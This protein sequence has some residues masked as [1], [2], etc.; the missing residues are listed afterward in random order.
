MLKPL[1]IAFL[2]LATLSTAQKKDGTI[3]VEVVV[4]GAETVPEPVKKQMLS[5]VAKYAR[6]EAVTDALVFRLGERLEDEF[7]QHGYF[8]ARIFI[9]E[10]WRPTQSPPSGQI[11]QIVYIVH[12]GSTYRLGDIHF[13][14]ATEFREAQLRSLIPLGE[15]ELFDVEKMRMGIRQLR[16]C[17]A[18]HGFINFTPIPN[19]DIDDDRKLINLTFDLDEGAQYRI[20]RITLDGQEPHPGVGRHLL[21]AWEPHIGEIY[22]SAFVEEVME[23][24]RNRKMNSSIHPSLADAARKTGPLFLE[25]SQHNDS[26]TVDIHLQFLDF[27]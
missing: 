1:S 20:G 11:I 27:K 21:D 15:K 16:D 5:E 13:K 2:L 8:K 4:R 14:G 17:Y 3:N 25:V 22:N 18:K 7:Q 19:T 26:H 24:S 9:P 10:N 6:D 12:E 23:L